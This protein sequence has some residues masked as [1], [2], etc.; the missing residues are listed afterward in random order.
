FVAIVAYNAVQIAIY[1]MFGF[2]L[3]DSIQRHYGVDVPWWAFA[4]AC[5]VAVHFCGARRIEFSGRL[6]GMLMI[7]EIAI[8]MLLDL[9][10]V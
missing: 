7:G 1:C 4:L 9:A 8:V 2:F 10:I 6:L 3:N 5:V